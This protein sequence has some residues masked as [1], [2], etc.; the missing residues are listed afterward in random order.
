MVEGGSD[1]GSRFRGFRVWGQDQVPS[2]KTGSLAQ[3][4]FKTAN[5]G[6]HTIIFMALN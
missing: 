1:L 2:L 5:P 3:D 4:S 6:T